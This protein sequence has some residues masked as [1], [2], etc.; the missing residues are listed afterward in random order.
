MNILM[1]KSIR[2]KR[3]KIIY[4]SMHVFAIIISDD[5]HVS[6][7]SDKVSV[8]GHLTSDPNLKKLY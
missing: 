6:V 8:L 1:S 7:S 4:I 3:L 2:Q 5:C